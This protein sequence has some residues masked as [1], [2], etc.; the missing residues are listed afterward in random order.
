MGWIDLARE[1]VSLLRELVKGLTDPDVRKAIYELKLFK[2][3][4]KAN[5]YAERAFNACD[6][7]LALVLE[8][9]NPKAFERLL[10][11]YNDMKEKFN[12]YD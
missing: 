7:L 11:N 1:G 12:K 3:Y 8:T 2:H 4:R 5:N 6:G 9:K 10:G